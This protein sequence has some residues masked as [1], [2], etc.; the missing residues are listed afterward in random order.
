MEDDIH[1]EYMVSTDL[2]ENADLDGDINQIPTSSSS[3]NSWPTDTDSS[4]LPHDPTF[5]GMYNTIHIDEKWF[6]MTKK[7]ENYYLLQDEEVPLRTYKSKNFIE[8]V[9]FLAAIARPRFDAHGKEVFSGKIGIF[10][11]VTQEPAKRNS[12]NRVAGTLET[13]PIT[14]VNKHVIRTFLIEKILPVIKEKWPIEEKGSPIFIQ[15]D[16]ARTHIDCHDEEFCR[17]ASQDGFD[18]RIMCQPANS[19]DLNILD[20]G[21]FNAIQSLQYKESL[22]SIDELVKVV[23]KSFETFSTVKSNHIFLTLQSC[24]IEIMKIRGSQKYKIP[25]FKKEMLEHQ[26]QLPKQLKCDPT[27]VQDVLRYLN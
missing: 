6:Y 9:M 17:V 2:E 7:S 1:V 26:G 27:L 3:Y 4:S 12:I 23:E 22:N 15:Q 16:N 14:S 11:F 19:P 21:Y 24:M 18:I 5:L 25:H 13:K 8:K 10:P 20:L